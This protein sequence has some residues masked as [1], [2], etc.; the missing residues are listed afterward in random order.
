MLFLLIGN[1][2]TEKQT[3]VTGSSG[4]KST[5]LPPKGKNRPHATLAAIAQAST[6]RTFD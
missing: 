1:L 3:V 4:S 2:P 5:G 6:Y